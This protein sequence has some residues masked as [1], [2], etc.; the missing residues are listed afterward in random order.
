MSYISSL[1]IDKLKL[2]TLQ[3]ANMKRIE[4]QSAVY[5]F[6]EVGAG[7]TIS[8]GLATIQLLFE[9]SKNYEYNNIL[10]IT[11]PSV[12]NQFKK[13]WEDVLNLKCGAESSYKNKKYYIKVI[14][15][16]YRNIQKVKRN[17]DFIIVDEA[18][19]FLNMETRRYEELI[20]LKCKK[21]MF[22][23]ATPLRYYRK[24][25]DIYPK[26]A[27]EVYSTKEAEKEI[28]FKV[29]KD[30][31]HKY[32]EDKEKLAGSFDVNSPVTRYFKETVRN[33]EK[34][35]N[36]EEF[37]DK[38]PIRL[39]PELWKCDIDDKNQYLCETINNIIRT[40][41]KSKF[42]V[43]V[44]RIKDAEDISES[45]K[46]Y[47]FVNYNCENL[48]KSFSIITGNTEDR[49]RKLE[50]FST[51]DLTVNLPT[52]LIMTYQIAEQGID[53]PS[54][55]YVI[56]YHIPASPSSLEQRFGRIDR[57][58][59]LH[60]EL[61]IC[62]LLQENGQATKETNTNNFYI[63]I[64]TFMNEFLPLFPSK[65]CLL[66]HEVIN[67]I[68][69]NRQNALSYYEYLK[70]LCNNDGLFYEFYDA[71]S[72]TTTSY[73]NYEKE[74]IIQLCYFFWDRKLEFDNDIDITKNNFIKEIEKLQNQTKRN[75]QNL[76]WWE[77]NID[78]LSND[79][80]Y[81]ET[82]DEKIDWNK[83]YIIK[84]ID[85]KESAKKITELEE[86]KLFSEIFREPIEV[87]RAWNKHKNYFEKYF[88]YAFGKI[89]KFSL[90][91]PKDKEYRKIFD[92][93][94]KEAKDN[95]FGNEYSLLIYK[96]NDLIPTL[97]FFKMCQEYKRIIHSL[98]FN[99]KGGYY[100]NYGFNP[101]KSSIEILLHR[102]TDFNMS[103]EF[104]ENYS[105]NDNLFYFNINPNSVSASNWLK[106]FYIYSNKKEFTIGNFK[107]I[108]KNKFK[109]DKLY[110]K[111]S[112]GYIN[113]TDYNLAQIY[114]NINQLESEIK[115]LEEQYDEE[116]YQYNNAVNVMLDGEENDFDALSELDR[117]G[118]LEPDCNEL[119][120]KKDELDKYKNDEANIQWS[121]SLFY[122]FR[123]GLIGGKLRENAEYSIEFRRSNYNGDIRN[124][125]CDEQITKEIINEID[126]K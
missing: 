70:T 92:N 16:D 103:Q 111:D 123:Y 34:K 72:S 18:H 112:E 120:E 115:I 9:S 37:N 44:N 109:Y 76:R 122:H 14:N 93:F 65:N 126:R 125:S 95:F 17:W 73:L 8:A 28:I 12:T 24:D 104:F 82:N 74:G 2:Y 33:I 113:D 20:K 78:S 31:L 102:K 10:V 90:I 80:F 6:D 60:N 101:L 35:E 55:N 88:E 114:I 57:L 49:K 64:N 110:L 121:R 15:Y 91:F 116:M 97:P 85:A 69:V 75:E 106:L 81:V 56:N 58:N 59:S 124:L 79:L 43:F 21:I 118:I 25:L 29:L 45:F 108:G 77:K 89:N 39:V 7:K 3:L 61:K 50:I 86:Y 23:T 27:S 54:Y 63:A 1:D 4:K 36:G 48:E 107:E 46:K 68:G 84:H 11:A 66:T 98:A 47:N 96:I 100:K 40:D 119:I 52:V 71:I 53:L 87:M 62:F 19:E 99:D 13:K 83:S 38:E 51:N 32:C 94:C 26:I 42:V 105:T 30:K 117:I 5:I 22:M 41:T 67:Y